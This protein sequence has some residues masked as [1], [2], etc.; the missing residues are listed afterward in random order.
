MKYNNFSAREFNHMSLDYVKGTITKTSAKK[1][2]LLDE[3]NWYRSMPSDLAVFVP[4]V[5]DVK[6]TSDHVDIVMELFPYS[7]LAGAWLTGCS[8]FDKWSKIIRDLFKV[9]KIMEKHEA[10]LNFEELNSIYKT[11]TAQRL[12]EIQNKNPYVADMMRGDTITINGVVYKNFSVLRN[13]LSDKIERLLQ[14]DRR[15]V[16]HG[17]YCFSNILFDGNDTYRFV[18][19]RGGFYAQGIYGDPR[20]DIAKLR[21]SFVGLYD[22]IIGD[23][24]DL[25]HYGDNAF[26]FKI[27]A[28]VDFDKYEKFFDSVASEY[29]FDPDD[30]KLIEALLF[31][32]M[33]PLHSDKPEHQRA[34]YLIAIKKLNEVIY[35]K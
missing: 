27:N 21:H 32:T 2:K 16:C 5:F 8:D 10:E 25:K 12:D 7:N 34:F 22:F 9:H 15:T 23:L 4:K 19:P 26:D 35:G 13:A 11:K 28:N 3:A 33:I 29:G 18:D 24:F 6:E 14:Y 20:Y 17:D 31:L 1:Q 30:I